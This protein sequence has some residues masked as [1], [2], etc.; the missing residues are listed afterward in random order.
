MGSFT[1]QQSCS[2]EAQLPYSVT[3]LVLLHLVPGVAILVLYLA[4]DLSR[5]PTGGR[6]FSHYSWLR[7]S[8]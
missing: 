5:D 4:P 2:G 6:L 7:C 8:A 1:V 3:K